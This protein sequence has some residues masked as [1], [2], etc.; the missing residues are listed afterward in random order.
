M[1]HCSCVNN[2][3]NDIKLKPEMVQD[4]YYDV[5]VSDLDCGQNW[6]RTMDSKLTLVFVLSRLALAP[7][8]VTDPR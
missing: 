3:N 7:W 1:S 6:P 4:W 5:P 8:Q 2:Q